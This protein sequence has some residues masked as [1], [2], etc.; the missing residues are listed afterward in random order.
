MKNSLTGVTTP[1]SNQGV[2]TP[3]K[4]II[5]NADEETHAWLAAQAK[6]Q[7]RSIG[8]QALFL[9]GLKRPAKPSKKKGGKR[10]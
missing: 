6:E 2:T 4:Q 5:I 8:N 3:M 7:C 1:I 10:A 9:L